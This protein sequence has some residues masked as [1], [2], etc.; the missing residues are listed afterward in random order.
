MLGWNYRLPEVNAAI[1]LAQ[2]ERIDEL[3]VKVAILGGDS[4]QLELKL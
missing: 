3:T 1:A 4:N 2:L